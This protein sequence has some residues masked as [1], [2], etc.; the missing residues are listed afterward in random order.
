MKNRTKEKKRSQ[1]ERWRRAV[2]WIATEGKNTTETLYFNHFN[3]IQSEFHIRFTLGRYTDCRNMALV[4][5]KTIKS[6]DFDADLGD[7]GFCV[8]DL[9]IAADKSKILQI[10]IKENA[11][12]HMEF[13]LS[14]PCFEVWF[15]CHFGY[16]TRVFE[17]GDA[18]ISALRKKVRNY[19][20]N[21]DVFP[22]IYSKTKEAIENA[23]RLAKH[24]KEQG[25]DRGSIHANPFTEV[26]KIVRFLAAT[27]SPPAS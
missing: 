21:A 24:H 16:S 4:L 26:Y 19:T 11:K 20:K 12:G 25:Y 3:K 18:V 5:E 14:N 9:D 27:A 17:S 13:I 6:A 15:L 7:K 10:L 23:E 8:F 2:F 1:I 22:L